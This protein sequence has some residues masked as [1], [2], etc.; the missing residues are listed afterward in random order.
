MYD[1]PGRERFPNAPLEFVA[2]EIKFPFAPRLSHDSTLDDIVDVLR[3]D[4]PVPQK[5]QVPAGIEFTL[6]GGNAVPKHMEAHKILR[7]MNRTKNRSVVITPSSLLLETTLYE[8]YDEFRASLAA[9]VGALGDLDMIVGV[10][11]LGLR[12]I[13][14][15]RV[16]GHDGSVEAWRP[17][18]APALLASLEV[19]AGYE[20]ETA[21]GVVRVRTGAHSQV[22]VRYATLIGTG[23][24]N[25]TLKKRR[26][27]TEGPFFVIDIDSSWTGENEIN[28]FS[29]EWT[30]STFDKLHEPTGVIFLRSVSESYKDEIARGAK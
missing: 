29:M 1:Y 5:E 2:A 17:W 21:E 8:T 23:V 4:F 6:L 18:V 28:E 7:C 10:E 16:P 14:E 22:L 12:Y 20:A 3:K 15:L 30:M 13:D 25:D 19:V 9:V 11:R 24:V 27:V 26:P